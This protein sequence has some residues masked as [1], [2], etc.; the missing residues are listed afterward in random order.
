MSKFTDRRLFRKKNPE[1]PIVL[2]G[3]L[4][5]G[6]GQLAVPGRPNFF[7]CRI[8][9]RSEVVYNDRVDAQNDL[10]VDVGRD[11]IMGAET[12]GIFKVLSSRS[13]APAGTSA[14]V[15]G[16]FAPASRY[17]IFEPG[18]G[19]D[20]I[21]SQLRQIMPLRVGPWDA[22]LVQIWYGIVPTGSTDVFIPFQTIDM[23]PYIPTTTGKSALVLITIDD[24]GAVVATKGNEF[25]TT[26]ITTEDQ[27]LAQ[28]PADP[29]DTVYRSAAVRVYYGQTEVQE[30]RVS[31][32]IRD[33][34]WMQPNPAAVTASDLGLGNVT[35]TTDINK[36]V[37]VPQAAAIKAAVDNIFKLAVGMFIKK[38]GA[39]AFTGDQSMGSHKITN[40]TNGS[41]AQDAAA[42]GQIPTSLPPSGTAGGE[43]AGTYPNPTLTN[44]AVIA[45]VLTGFSAAAGTVAAT[46]TILQAFQKVVGNIAL[47]VS[48][49]RLIN[50]TAPLVGGGDLTADL[51]L[52]ITA[53]TVSAAGSM[54]AADKQK[55]NGPLQ[56][57]LR[58]NFV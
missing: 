57:I 2:P 38:N 13:N 27:F 39:T 18:G 55:L 52:S 34:R 3:Q 11:T 5:D 41:S 21:F 7:Y 42:F 47:K 48:S 20:P 32:D 45:K 8:S 29:D 33:L 25:S 9:G 46:D 31:S 26:A 10:M 51:T 19:Q 28:I 16:G 24:I 15:E 56:A 40:L 43:L 30:G 58:S 12:P 37:S 49:S 14:I 22:L 50:T 17:E 6:Y 23:E 36:P 54:S 1:K 53:A 35:N 4:G 44:A